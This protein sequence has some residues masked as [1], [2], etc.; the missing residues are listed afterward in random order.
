MLSFKDDNLKKGFSAIAEA[1]QKA[2]M[3]APFDQ[4]VTSGMRSPDQNAAVGGVPNSF[5]TTGNAIDIRTRD[6]SPEDIEA[7]KSY[8]SG[9]GFQ[10]IYEGDHLHVE[11]MGKNNNQG[12]V[13]YNPSEDKLK[14]LSPQSPNLGMGANSLGDQG[15][16]PFGQN[17]IGGDTEPLGMNPNSTLQQM[18]GLDPESMAKQK[19]AYMFSTI[20][21]GLAQVVGSLNPNNG[22]E[23]QKVYMAQG[24]KIAQDYAN[25]Q[26]SAIAEFMKLQ[27]GGDLITNNIKEYKYS[28]QDP[29]FKDFLKEKAALNPFANEKAMMDRE[30]FLMA[31]QKFMMDQTKAERDLQKAAL[32]QTLPA[33]KALVLSDGENLPG[34]LGRL[35]D[36]IKE[37]PSVMGPVVGRLRGLNPFDTTAQILNAQIESV[38]QLVGRFVEGGVLR[39][40]D[41][42]KYSKILASLSDNPKTALAKIDNMEKELTAKYNGHLKSLGSAGYNVSKFNPLGVEKSPIQKAM[43]GMG[44]NKQMNADD[45]QAIDW[46][47]QNPNDPRAVKI[48]QELGVQ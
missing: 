40:E 4:L 13:Q 46:A 10:P 47:R 1:L 36:A 6:K 48:L 33:D 16:Q 37:N 24:N 35:R 30:R 45:Q 21:N 25:K 41:S 31:Q 18:F 26:K 7:M 43:S 11:P 15:A 3:N 5:H 27:N 32:G 38:K 42:V 34:T 9:Q 14:L 19:K 12:T 28:Q 29:R 20:M 44:Q 39:A 8:Y 22:R 23:L 17:P 2:A